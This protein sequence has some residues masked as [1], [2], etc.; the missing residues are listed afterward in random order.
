VQRSPYLGGPALGQPEAFIQ[1]QDGMFDQAG[2]IGTGAK[3]FLLEWMVR[4][5]TWVKLH[6][7]GSF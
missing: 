6:S 2:N 4:Y 3:K 5:A 1:A 7:T